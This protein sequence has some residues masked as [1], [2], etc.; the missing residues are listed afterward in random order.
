MKNVIVDTEEDAQAM[1]FA[2]VIRSVE[3][4]VEVA[5]KRRVP[6]AIPALARLIRFQLGQRS[7]RDQH[8]LCVA[9]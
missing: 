2:I 5:V 3:I 9:F 6:R 7:A 8:K 4:I 1:G